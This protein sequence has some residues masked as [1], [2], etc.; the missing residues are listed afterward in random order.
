MLAKK[1][2]SEHGVKWPTDGEWAGD[3]HHQQFMIKQSIYQAL[4]VSGRA[5]HLTSTETLPS[6]AIAPSLTDNDV[7]EAVELMIS[8]YGLQQWA[9]FRV[10]VQ[11]QEA[12]PRKFKEQKEKKG[13]K[14]AEKK[15][16]AKDSGSGASRIKKEKEA[17]GLGNAK[18]IY[19]QAVPPLPTT[20]A[21]A[22]AAAVGSAEPTA[23]SSAPSRSAN[24][25]PGAALGGVNGATLVHA[26]E[27]EAEAE[28]KHEAEEEGEEEE[29]EEEEELD[30]KAQAIRRLRQVLL[31]GEFVN[32]GQEQGDGDGDG[33]GEGDDGE[34]D[35]GKLNLGLS[36]SSSSSSGYSST[37]GGVFRANKSGLNPFLRL[38][39][40]PALHELIL[41]FLP[42]RFVRFETALWV[43]K[44]F[45]EIAKHSASYNYTIDLS[46]VYSSMIYG[47]SYGSILT[48]E[49]QLE[50]TK[51]QKAWKSQAITHSLSTLQRVNSFDQ[52]GKVLKLEHKKFGSTTFN[53]IFSSMPLCE[54]LHL[55]DCKKIF[56]NSNQW[57]ALKNF[58]RLKALSY[59]WAWDMNPIKLPESVPLLESLDFTFCTNYI[60]D[61]PYESGVIY[62]LN[63]GGNARNAPA[64][65][66]AWNDAFLNALATHCPRLKRI[67]LSGNLMFSD[68]AFIALLAACPALHSIQ[69]DACRGAFR[70]A[71]IVFDRLTPAAGAYKAKKR[72]IFAS[73]VCFVHLRS[74][75]TCQY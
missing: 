56:D 70:H 46:R 69:F 10:P 20:A 61:S 73:M 15:P 33:D 59:T 40:H 68:T 7:I 71:S 53:S 57:A 47:G 26:A 41:S 64:P 23:A 31:G 29:E 45:H 63:N 13:K 60:D 8:T 21:A 55:T 38:D 22:A 18:P 4:V 51:K 34:A 48:N 39:A 14:E 42:F 24:A 36:G 65:R 75:I 32:A 1:L 74:K 52:Q 43:S 3:D 62:L 54:E 2:C 49:Q 25:S 16:K 37:A 30:E 35:K 44:K 19:V 50:R 28:E 27:A 72:Y 6:P 66:L 9:Q 17:K 67:K 11:Q 58:K 5:T 12:A